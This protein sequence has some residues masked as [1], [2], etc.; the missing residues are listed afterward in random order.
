VIQFISVAFCFPW[1]FIPNK[2]VVLKLQF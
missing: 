1:R 2:G